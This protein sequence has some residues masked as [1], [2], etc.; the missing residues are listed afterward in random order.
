MAIRDALASRPH[1]VGIADAD[2]QASLSE[3]G[4]DSLDLIIVLSHFEEHWGVEVDNEAADPLSF[5]SLGELAD[6]LAARVNS[7]RAVA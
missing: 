4:M 2:E 1:L 6:M 3:I 7:A 5:Q